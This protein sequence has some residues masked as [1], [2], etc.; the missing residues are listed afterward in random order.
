MCNN[1]SRDLQ[2][3]PKEKS[4][5]I[6]YKSYIPYVKIIDKINEETIKIIYDRKV[7]IEKTKNSQL[8]LT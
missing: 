1:Q 4:V 5:E 8:E 7:D 3:N 6:N 2:V